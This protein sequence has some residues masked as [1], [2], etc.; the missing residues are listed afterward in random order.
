[1]LNKLILR[2]KNV[3]QGLLV[4]LLGT[5]PALKKRTWSLLNP[6]QKLVTNV[7]NAKVKALKV[8]TKINFYVWQSI[9]RFHSSSV[10]K[11]NGLVNAL[12]PLSSVVRTS[13]TPM[14]VLV[15]ILLSDSILTVKSLNLILVCGAVLALYV[16]VQ[17]VLIFIWCRT[18]SMSFKTYFKA[19]TNLYI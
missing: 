11:T 19:F 13:I 6:V 2:Y 10:Y 15:L 1:M 18:S 3:R 16:V 8:L 9:K 7:Q 4:W 17:T 5:W 14:A 12:K